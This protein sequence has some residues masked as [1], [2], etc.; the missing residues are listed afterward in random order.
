VFEG[1]READNERTDHGSASYQTPPSKGEV[2][3][4]DV[5]CN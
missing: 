2:S 1:R 4:F 5:Q 3:P